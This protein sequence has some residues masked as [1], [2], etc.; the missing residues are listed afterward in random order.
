MN[1]KSFGDLTED[2]K[3]NIGTL[4]SQEFDLIVGIPR[5]GMIPAYIIG[6]YLNVEVTDINNFVNNGALSRGITRET[7][8]GLEFA[9]QAKKVLL[10]DDSILTGGSFRR[11]MNLLSVDQ[12]KKVST[13]AVYADSISRNDLDFL[14]EY[15]PFPRVFEWNIFHRDLLG[16]ACVSID[17]VL[18][19][20]PAEEEKDDGDKY[21]NFL[22]TAKPHIIPTYKI[23][24]LVTSRLEKYRP[25]TEE[26]LASQGVEYDHLIM[27]DL[28]LKSEKSKHKAHALHKATYYSSSKNLELFI[29]SDIKLSKKI[30]QLT[31]R[32]VFCVDNNVMVTP[33]LLKMAFTSPKISIELSKRRASELLPEAIKSVLRPIFRF[34]KS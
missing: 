13:L 21:S 5:S 26:W 7:K 12:K 11:T 15:V 32:P 30:V 22:S 2:I 34:I 24:S 19:R 23:H 27:Q 1:F 6:L 3:K 14:L 9:H 18:C 31:G 10:V 16:R 28:A 4:S 33:S 29:E 8:K 17:G 25:Q 20:N